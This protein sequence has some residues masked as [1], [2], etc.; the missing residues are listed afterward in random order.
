MKVTVKLFY[1]LKEKAGTGEILLD[2]PD[3]SNVGDIKNYLELHFPQ[4][5][6]HL[7][8]IMILM[9]KK[10]V[11]DDDQIKEGAEIS[12]LTPVGGG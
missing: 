9:D 5:R 11:L 8:N 12:F 6:S 1:H 2:F 7:D 10:I 4:L 3:Q